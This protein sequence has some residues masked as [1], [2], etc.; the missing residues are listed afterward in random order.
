MFI[1]LRDWIPTEELNWKYLSLNPEKIDWRNLSEN[2][3]IFE[4]DYEK[5][6][7]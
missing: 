4:I 7:Q 1:K 6:K 2:Q 3:G 5:I